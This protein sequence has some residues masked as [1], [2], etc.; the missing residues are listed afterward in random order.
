VAAQQP[1]G[2]P[3]ST[4]ARILVA[5][6][7]VGDA[8][9]VRKLL[10]DDFDHVVGSSDPNKVVEDFETHRP[11]VL[12]LAFKTLEKSE[13]YYLT[14]Y[15]LGTL[16]HGLPHRTLIL[17]NQEDLRRVYAL[18][19]KEYFDDYVLFWPIP[20][21]ALRL[22]MAVHH[23]L[24]QLVDS[25]NGAP[26][27]GEFAAQARRLAELET[28]LSQY[29]ARGS[30][31]IDAASRSLQQAQQGIGLALDGF[32]REL[33]E[34]DLRGLIE[35]KDAPGWQREIDRLKTGEIGPRLD[36]VA[37][38]V[39]PVRDWAGALRTELAPQFE[40]ARALQTLAARVRPLVLLVDDDEYQHKL[41][42]A[43]LLK[44]NLELLF[45]SS[46]DEAFAMLRRHRPNLILMDFELPDIDG[47]EALKR[48]KAAEPFSTVPI[49]M[50]TGRSDRRVVGESANAGAS[51]FLVK[52]FNQQTL[53]AK[54]RSCLEG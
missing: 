49:V 2:R 50:V 34:G 26:S 13:R 7:V 22:P 21:D 18:C 4:G 42:R 29:A 15:R 10:R 39:T 5:T 3:V 43:L 44:E 27:V 38:A 30:D 47:V 51:G 20:H 11:S 23:A 8:D 54:V 33:A 25:E 52:P 17:C 40:S 48:I 19:K 1:E 45:A 53:L 35:V 28:L 37:A 9:L 31:R 16:V 12:I 41:L 36:A 14:L 24:R 6:D 32:S 46:G